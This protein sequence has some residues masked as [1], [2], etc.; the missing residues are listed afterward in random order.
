M[1]YTSIFLIL[2]SNKERCS[3]DNQSNS[4]KWTIKDKK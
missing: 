3:K 1:D 4:L 2:K